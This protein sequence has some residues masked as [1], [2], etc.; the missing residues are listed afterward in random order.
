MN[1]PYDSH[2]ESEWKDITQRLID[3]HPLKECIVE[4]CLK[5][6][7]SILNGK[8]NSYLNLMI[9]EM[10]MSPQVMGAL[11]H[12]II[13]V[14]IERNSAVKGFRKGTGVEK[15][16]VCEFDD[17]FSFEIKTSSSKNSI[18]G[19]RSYAKSVNGKDKNGYFLTIN[20]ENLDRAK[21]SNPGIRLIQ[22]GWLS[23]SDWIGQTSQTGQ[24]AHLS[25][26]AK[27]NKFIVLYAKE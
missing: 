12:D 27:E 16:V 2:K 17:A 1:N 26:S 18:F 22:F 15:D 19:N 3:K 13:P 23:H 10:S 5:S 9:K 11:L 20:F 14:Y 6:W 25:K 24:Q 21:T 7:S 8:I 4:Y